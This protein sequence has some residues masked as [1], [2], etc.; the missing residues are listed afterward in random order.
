[1]RK[2]LRVIK[3]K[4]YWGLLTGKSDALNP[5]KLDFKH[6]W[7]VFQSWVRSLFPISKHVGQQIVWRR[8]QVIEKSP[9]CWAK[10]EC[11]Q[12]GCYMIP[13]TK[14]DMECEHGCYPPI[15]SKKE[16]KK[17]KKDNK[18]NLFE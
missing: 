12:C 16:W 6:A 5:A 3:V 9:E 11:I 13:K 2:N 15:M 14:V 8:L 10:G 7:A 1:M 18:I 4:H 17:Y